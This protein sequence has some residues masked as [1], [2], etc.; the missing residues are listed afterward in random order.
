MIRQIAAIDMHM[1]LVKNGKIPWRLPSDLLYF[2]QLTK[3]LG[4]NV[5]MGN[6]TYRA[7]GKPLDGRNNYVVSH[8][9]LNTP[10]VHFVK[11]PISF[12]NN[13]KEDIW[14]IGGASIYQTT[15]AITDELYLTEI[16]ADF[17]CDGFY[18]K[19]L[20]F[21]IK[22]YSDGPFIENDIAFTFNKYTRIK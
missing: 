17:N 3:T 1:G 11:D 13:F 19:Y 5:L 4:G 18:P 10:G 9:D 22:D 8:Q 7:I 6:G 20:E 14:V 15:L 21:F 16:E 12:L 2:D